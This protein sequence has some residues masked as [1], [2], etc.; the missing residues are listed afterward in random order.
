MVDWVVTPFMYDGARVAAMSLPVRRSPIMN[1][2]AMRAAAAALCVSL[3]ASLGAYTNITLPTNVTLSTLIVNAAAKRTVVFLHGFPSGSYMWASVFDSPALS[4]F[5]LVAP[6]LRGYNRSTVTPGVASYSVDLLA[7]DVAHLIVAIAGEGSRV[8]L[9]AHDWGGG[10]AWWLAAERPDLLFSL[11]ILNMAHPSGWI[12]AVRTDAAQQAASVYVL[13]FVNSLFTAIATADDN[14]LLKSVFAGEAFWPTVEPAYESSWDVAGTVNASLNYYRANIVPHCNLSC[15][16]ASCWKQG[17]D[18]KF[19]DI[20]NEGVIA[21]SLP[22]LVQWGLLDTAFDDV[23]Q[24]AFISSKVR[25]PLQVIKFANASHW[26][27]QEEP[28]AVASNL[29]AFFESH[30]GRARRRLEVISR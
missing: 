29:A 10:V 3:G 24:L 17:V 23:F 25:G 4:T 20:P 16:E 18:S 15:V 12:E 22:V 21:P 2:L 6:D 27:P 26:L 7:N 5:R 8:N 30:G 19:D 9:V 28:V 11:A 13:S 1:S 14:A